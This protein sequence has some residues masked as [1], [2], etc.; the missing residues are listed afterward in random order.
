MALANSD[1]AAT[2]QTAVVEPVTNVIPLAANQ[3]AG[4]TFP[5]ERKFRFNKDD[6]GNQRPAVTLQVPVPSYNGLVNIL[7]NAE[8]PQG[9]KAF[10]LLQQAAADVIVSELRSY[11]ADNANA[12]QDTI[13]WDKF[14]FE[15]I[16]QIPQGIRGVSAIAKEL[17]EKFAKAYVAAMPALTNTTAEVAAARVG[18]LVQKFRPLTGNPERKKIIENLMATLAVFV[19]SNTPGLDEFEPILEFLSKKADELKAEDT[20][21]TADALG[22]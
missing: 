3:T 7:N 18:V 16:S 17:W 11:V 14:T 5:Q 22:F 19:N 4:M 9:K 12:A 1:Q 10:E 21:V 8:T 20:I 2:E 13:P 6:L 15:A